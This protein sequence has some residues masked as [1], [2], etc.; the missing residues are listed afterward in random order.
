MDN[1]VVKVENEEN[2][3]LL[4]AMVQIL[5]DGLVVILVLK[6]QTME[7]K[8]LAISTLITVK[9]SNPLLIMLLF[10]RFVG[11]HITLPQ[12]VEIV[13]IIWR[14]KRSTSTYSL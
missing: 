13:M 9:V 14:R 4:V 6:N 10:V 12:N 8:H 11:G 3:L 2:S 1:K 7:K 5:V